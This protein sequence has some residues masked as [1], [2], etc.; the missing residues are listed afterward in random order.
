MSA[1]RFWIPLLAASALALSA[2]LAHATAAAP[3]CKGRDLSIDPAV[4]PD[5]AAHADELVNSEGLLWKIEKD[6]VAPSYL[7]GTIHSTQPSALDLAHEAAHYIDGAKT[8]AT[9]LG[10]P[11]DAADKIN[12]TAG[13]MSAALSA[14]RDTI[15]GDLSG[16]D[17]GLVEDFLA[18]HGFPGDMAHHLKL[19]FLAVATS[20]PACETEGERLG[21]PEVDDTLAATAKSRGV[22]VV[23][24]ETAQEQIDAVAATPPGSRP[25]SWSPAPAR[26]ISTTTPMSPCS[27]STRPGAPPSPSPS[28]TR[29]RALPPRNATPRPNSPGGCWSAATKR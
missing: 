15:A 9:E 8:V 27:I 3:F 7:Y 11:F 28:S 26:P 20:L 29:R 24:L 10:G 18:G 2:S 4:K 14:D 23:A 5:L 21:L 1:S 17:V 25:R 19:W 22:R 12:L 13:M 6:G 16:P